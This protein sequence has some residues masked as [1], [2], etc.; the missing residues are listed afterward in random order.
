VKYGI[1]GGS[2]VTH[3]LRAGQ[4]PGEAVFVP[5]SGDAAED[6]GRQL[7]L[8]TSRTGDES[9]L[10]VL[11]ASDRVPAGFHASWTNDEELT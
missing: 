9:E 3:D 6:A 11:D 7:R 8:V 10:L 4:A 5:T 1:L 2:V